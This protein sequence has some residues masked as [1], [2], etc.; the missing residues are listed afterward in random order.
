M[1]DFK[2]GMRIS[3][4]QRHIML[5]DRQSQIDNAVALALREATGDE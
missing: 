4:T 5:G 1:L 3:L 2:E